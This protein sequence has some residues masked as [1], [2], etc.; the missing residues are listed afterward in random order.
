MTSAAPHRY[1]GPI[2]FAAASSRASVEL[3]AVNQQRPMAMASSRAFWT[4]AAALCT[5]RRR[6]E[7]MAGPKARQP[8]R[9]SSSRAQQV[10]TV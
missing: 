1:G 5:W 9:P 6:A 8:P 2:A 3:D 7:S 4:V 10:G